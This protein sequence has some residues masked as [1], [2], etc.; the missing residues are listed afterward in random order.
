M[1]KKS[2]WTNVLQPPKNAS[3]GW[4]GGRSAGQ[5]DEGTPHMALVEAAPTGRTK[6]IDK[7]V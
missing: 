1:P 2:Q 5:A 4:Q 7:P 3:L 6:A